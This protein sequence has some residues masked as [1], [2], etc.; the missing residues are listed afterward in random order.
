MMAADRESETIPLT[1]V[2][3]TPQV[4]AKLHNAANYYQIQLTATQTADTTAGGYEDRMRYFQYLADYLKYDFL[5]RTVGLM[6]EDVAFLAESEAIAYDTG[7]TFDDPAQS[8]E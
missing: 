6:P 8:I 2:R 3:V 1:D 7:F 4:V 5:G